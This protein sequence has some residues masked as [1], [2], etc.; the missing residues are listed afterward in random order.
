MV[1]TVTIN[2]SV[3]YIMH[4][5]ELKEGIVNRSSSEEL[6]IGGKGINVSFVLKEFGIESS[7][8]GFC[9]GFTGAY[10]K[11]KLSENGIKEEMI[12]LKTGNSR[13]N[14][15]LKGQSET[16]INGQGPD[17]SSESMEELYKILEKINDGD[18][19]VLSGSIP[20]T[21]S[22]DVYVNI[23]KKIK[24]KNVKTV[25]DATGQLLLKTLDEKPFLIKPNIYELA[26]LFSV[27]INSPD[28]AALYAGKLIE[29]GA[30]NVIVSM[31]ENGAVFVNKDHN[32]YRNARKGKTVNSTGAGDSM[33][34]GFIAGYIN[35]MDFE[36]AF[37]TAVET[38]T[39]ASFSAG[40]PKK[41]QLLDLI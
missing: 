34:A 30:Q 21:L 10:I 15:K 1:Y 5:D 8:L 38:G 16:E 39:I 32:I 36:K 19:L 3:D 26:D 29:R 22:D 24:G 9:S 23:L 18:F 25:V 11:D 13:I 41:E 35:N 14:V 17:I 2:P 31:G 7:A 12:N 28:A 40:L 6:Y 33:V 37:I 4:I 20:K 27:N